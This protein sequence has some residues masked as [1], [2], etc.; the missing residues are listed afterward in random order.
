VPIIKRCRFC[1]NSFTASAG[2]RG[3]CGDA[4]RFWSKVDRNG[5]VPAHRP[6]LGPCWNWTGGPNANYGLFCAG[7]HNH[8]AHRY[9]LELAIG[10]ELRAQACHRCDNKRCV[11]PTHL[12][13][14]TQADNGADM[15]AKGRAASGERHTTRLHPDRVARGARHVSATHPELVPRGE[16]HG[17]AVLTAADV[18]EIR[19]RAAGGERRASIARSFGVNRTNIVKIVQFEAWKHVIDSTR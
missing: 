17:N 4:C 11:R 16:G 7:G 18:L 14:G 3:F 19:R 12:F 1:G 10:R 9:S 5:P 15:A 2:S 6:E 8:G 13:E